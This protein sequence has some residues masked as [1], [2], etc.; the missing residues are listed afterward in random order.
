VLSALVEREPGTGDVLRSVGYRAL[1]WRRGA[2]AFGL[3]ERAAA[4]RADVPQGRAAVAA[5]LADA[6]RPELA[7]LAYEAALDASARRALSED[8]R[9]IVALEHLTVVRRF[10]RSGAGPA[11]LRAWAERR[12]AELRDVVGFAEADLVVTLAW[13]TDETDVD[14]H[15][16]DPAGEDCHYRHRLTRAG[17]WITSDVTRGFGPEMVVLP[18]R[19]PGAHVVRLVYFR[20]DDRRLSLRSDAVVTL[21]EDWGR[22]TEHVT[23]RV[24]ALASGQQDVEVFRTK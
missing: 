24:V 13:S 9:R 2:D 14:L 4:L 23:R 12:A 6:G 17:A 22:P 11:A 20:S 19:A 1:E 21:H 3:L 5:A 7:M 16:V 15:V 18:K 8:G 10:L